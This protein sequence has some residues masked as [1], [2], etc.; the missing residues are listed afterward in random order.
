[1]VEPA[2]PVHNLF[3][4]AS[5]KGKKTFSRNFQQILLDLPD[6]YCTLALIPEPVINQGVEL[7]LNT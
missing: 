7:L 5:L 2:F 6:Q 4:N 1:M 3:L